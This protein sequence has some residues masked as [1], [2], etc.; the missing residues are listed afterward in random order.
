MK[1]VTLSGVRA[2]GA[3]TVPGIVVEQLGGE[4]WGLPR[5]YPMVAPDYAARRSVLAKEIRLGRKP[6]ASDGRSSLRLYS[7]WRRASRGRRAV[8]K[9]G[10]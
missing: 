9:V 8:R 3:L 2:R 7:T 5:N 6:A 10:A 1:L 4:R